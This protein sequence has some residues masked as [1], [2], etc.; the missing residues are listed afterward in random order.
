MRHYESNQLS[1]FPTKELSMP[2]DKPIA[3]GYKMDIGMTFGNDQERDEACEF[4]VRDWSQA[5]NL[6]S[7]FEADQADLELLM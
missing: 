1:Q 6:C 7:W 2:I 5:E 4:R 3:N